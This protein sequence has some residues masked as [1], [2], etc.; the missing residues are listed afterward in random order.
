MTNRR[1]IREKGGKIMKRRWVILPVL[2]GVAG[3]FLVG[4][5]DLPAVDQDKKGNRKILELTKKVQQLEDRVSKLEKRSSVI[6]VPTPQT[7]AV[8]GK[9]VPKSWQRKEINGIPFYIVPLDGSG[10]RGR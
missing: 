2:A 8:P 7:P 6:A 10:K 5:A 9:G 3:L 4:S 1:P